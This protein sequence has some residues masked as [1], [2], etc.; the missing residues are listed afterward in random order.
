MSP[1]LGNVKSPL[2]A[3]S[4]NAQLCQHLLCCFVFGRGHGCFEFGQ[5]LHIV[6][7]RLLIVVL[8]YPF[9]LIRGTARNQR[10][11]SL[12]QGCL[13]PCLSHVLHPASITVN[14]NDFVSQAP[15]IGLDCA[16]FFQ[17]VIVRCLGVPLLHIILHLGIEE[18]LKDLAESL[19]LLFRKVL[20]EVLGLTVL[21]V[22]LAS[23]LPQEH[24]LLI[25]AQGGFPLHEVLFEA[26]HGRSPT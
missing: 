15:V 3:H 14:L 23:R 1:E 4:R 8:H 6:F 26:A 22:E 12:G 18:F 25:A 20:V 5:E 2:L 10:L 24:G 21:L 9:L 13:H 11:V 16:L 19:D 7:V 17:A